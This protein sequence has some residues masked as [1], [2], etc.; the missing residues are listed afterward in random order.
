MTTALLYEDGTMRIANTAQ[1]RFLL[2]IDMSLDVGKRDILDLI[3]EALDSGEIMD[4]IKCDEKLPAKMIEATGWPENI[5][6]CQ[7][8]LNIMLD[9]VEKYNN[10][11]HPEPPTRQRDGSEP[12]ELD[13]LFASFDDASKSTPR[14]DQETDQ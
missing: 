14:T 6:Y 1:E 13:E 3:P 5:T 4:L 9:V 12:D 7:A 11:H 8:L 10:E 2:Y